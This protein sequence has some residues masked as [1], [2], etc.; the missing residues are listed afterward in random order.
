[1]MISAGNFGRISPWKAGGYRRKFW[2][3]LPLENLCSQEQIL[4][5]PPPENGCSEAKI[6]AEPLPLGAPSLGDQR[7]ESPNKLG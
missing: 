5:E 6:L 3:N 7:L 4:A 2:Q 1:M